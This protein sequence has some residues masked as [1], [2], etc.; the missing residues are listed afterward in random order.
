VEQHGADRE[1]LETGLA[2]ALRGARSALAAPRGDRDLSARLLLV[3]AMAENDLGRNREALEHA[4]QAL[5]AR[6]G[7]P[8]LHYE[9]GVALYE[10]C[11][12]ADA[13]V[14]LQRVLADAPDDPWTIHYLS[15]VAERRGDRRRAAELER[16]AAALAPTEFPPSSPPAERDFAREVRQ[17][18]AALP[19]ADRQLLEGVPI[20]IQ[21]LP[22]LDDLTAADPPLSPSI[23]GLFRG[24]PVG[25]RCT[26]ADGPHCRSIVFYRVNLARLTRDPGELAAQV[27]VTL[28]HELG[29]LRGESDEELRARGLE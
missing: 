10:L 5:S 28:L 26:E 15:L 20:E 8:D 25:E 12:F 24:P 11:R 19:E 2:H 18:V 22:A 4:D 29:H 9:R 3:A 16:R 7:D 6:P 17:A 21:D 13:D 23:L 14:E 27:R 1:A